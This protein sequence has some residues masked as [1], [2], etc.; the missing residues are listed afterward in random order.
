MALGGLFDKPLY[1]FVGIDNLLFGLWQRCFIIKM[2]GPSFWKKYL[3][4]AL[5]I[6]TLVLLC[7]Q[8]FAAKF[9]GKSSKQFSL[10]FTINNILCIIAGTSSLS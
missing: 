10:F 5:K 2:F 6:M 3:F 7:H 9:L 8:V 1:I 4:R